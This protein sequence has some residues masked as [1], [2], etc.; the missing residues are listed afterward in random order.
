MII[1][2]TNFLIYIMKYKI[3]HN[4]EEYKSELAVPEQVVFELETLSRKTKKIKDREYAKLALVLLEKWN[5]KVL[6]ENGNA[7]EAIEKLAIKNKAKVGTMDKILINKLEKS[8]IS[9][10]KIRQK[11]LIR[12]A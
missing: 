9:V 8:G 12:K 2:D 4:L 7:D 1:L 11:K 3:A 10:L 6:N 5:V